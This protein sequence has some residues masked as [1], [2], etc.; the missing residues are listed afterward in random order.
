[1]G[2]VP[3][4][5]SDDLY[6]VAAEAAATMS[7]STAQQIAHWARLGKAVEESPGLSTAAVRELLAGA[8][9]YDQLTDAEQTVVLDVWRRQ[10]AARRE[11]L[12]F[13]RDFTRQGR[14]WSELDERGDVVVH[15]ASGEPTADVTK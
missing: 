3:V 10:F 7:R 6:D 11:A 13:A 1:M 12:D 9:G 14:Q 5:L 15:R 2:T 4:R 8:G